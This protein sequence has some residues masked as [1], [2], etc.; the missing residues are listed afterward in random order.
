MAIGVSKSAKFDGY[1]SYEIVATGSL[2]GKQVYRTVTVTC[3]DKATAYKLSIERELKF[4]DSSNVVELPVEAVSLSRL[5][6]IK[7]QF[8]EIQNEV[9]ASYVSKQSPT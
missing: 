9:L 2:G 1:G 4:R 3:F 8:L 6:Q 5:N 7:E